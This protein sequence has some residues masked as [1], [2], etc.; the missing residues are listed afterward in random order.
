[1]GLFMLIMGPLCPLVIVTSLRFCSLYS[2]IPLQALF[3]AAVLDFSVLK[4]TDIRDLIGKDGTIF[5][6]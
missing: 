4:V 5:T 2:Y 6:R 3:F 1:M